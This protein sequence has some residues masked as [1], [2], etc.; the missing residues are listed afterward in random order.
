MQ[1][2]KKKK[3]TELEK[4][5]TKGNIYIEEKVLMTGIKNIISS[6]KIKQAMQISESGGRVKALSLSFQK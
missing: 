1:K 5:K 2:K 3:G 6:W 4:I